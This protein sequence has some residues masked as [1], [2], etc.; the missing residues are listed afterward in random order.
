MVYQE[1]ISFDTPG[2]RHMPAESRERLQKNIR[3]AEEL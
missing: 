3:L 1:E 2:H